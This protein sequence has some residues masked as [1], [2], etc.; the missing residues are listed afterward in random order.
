MI[1]IIFLQQKILKLCIDQ[2][3]PEPKKL[4]KNKKQTVIARRNDE[5][6]PNYT[7]RICKRTCLLG[8]ASFLAM[9]IQ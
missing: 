1:A 4:S 9:T 2:I 8:I 5:A 6:I 7:G 3:V